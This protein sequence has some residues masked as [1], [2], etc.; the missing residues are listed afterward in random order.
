MSLSDNNQADAVE[1]F[2]STTR[3][4]DD[5]LNIDNPYF[6]QMVSQ[7]FPNELQL[8]KANSSDTE[9]PFLDLVVSI[10]NGIVLSNIYDKRDYFSFEIVNVPFLDGDVPRSL[11]YD[12]YFPFCESMF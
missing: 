10:T 2:N 5:L 7:V 9:A 8:N 11:S 6:E 12:V 4:L 3:Y 1:A